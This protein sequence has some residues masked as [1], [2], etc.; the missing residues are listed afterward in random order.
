[1]TTNTRMWLGRIFTVVPV[2]FLVFDG[3]IH[4]LNIAPVVAAT[5]QLGWPAV[6]PIV[7]GIELACLAL[8]VFPRTATLG[9]ILL[10]GYLGGAVATQVRVGAPMFS[11][12]LFPVYV[13]VLLWAGLYLRNDRVSALI[14]IQRQS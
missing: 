10:T 1:M 2:L 5:A 14:P 7:G 9:A 3:V 4:V 13:G 6:M 11:A 8:Y 12:A